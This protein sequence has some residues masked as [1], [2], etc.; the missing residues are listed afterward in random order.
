MFIWKDELSSV[1]F[2]LNIVSSI[3]LSCPNCELPILLGADSETNEIRPHFW[4]R[5]EIGFHSV[6]PWSVK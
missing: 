2:T 5:D 4:L 1:V 6:Q 3:T